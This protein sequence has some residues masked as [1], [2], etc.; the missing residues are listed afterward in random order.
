[1]ADNDDAQLTES[2]VS[3]VYDFLR[4]TG[5]G[6]AV[7]LVKDDHK[8]NFKHDFQLSAENHRQF[9]KTILS[10]ASAK[11]Y[12]AVDKK[13][14]RVSLSKN[15]MKKNATDIDTLEEWDAFLEANSLVETAKPINAWID[16]KNVKKAF[17]K[18][19]H[20]DRRRG[21][22]SDDEDEDGNPLMG[23][24]DEEMPFETKS[25]AYHRSQLEKKYGNTTD[26][27][28][29]YKDPVSG[30]EIPLT[31]LMMGAWSRAMHDGE[32]T[33][34]TPPNLPVFDAVNPSISSTSSS[35]DL[36]SVTTMVTSLAQLFPQI[37]SH[38]APAPNSSSSSTRNSPSKIPRF[39]HHMKENLGVTD[40]LDYRVHLEENQIGPDILNDIDTTS[41]LVKLGIPVRNAARLKHEAPIWWSSPAA[42]RPADYNDEPP[43]GLEGWD[44]NPLETRTRFEK[45][46]DD[47]SG[48]HT[49]W[50]K[51]VTEGSS[52]GFTWWYYCTVQSGMLPLPAS[53]V[54]ILDDP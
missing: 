44:A 31:L 34:F 29:T 2:L 20:E 38:N 53:C 43:R 18:R 36:Q 49:V 33:I 48:F 11:K 23:L 3:M 12:D 16:E 50:G 47:D 4:S 39:L 46:F 51:G 28:Y 41:D 13:V 9:L 24:K 17:E 52:T 6:K 5:S 22:N 45:R 37:S 42:K 21:D 8:K 54:P 40:A 1:M 26:R 19:D 7:K 10:L 32:A 30:E 14:F 27:S 35:S 25:I 15:K